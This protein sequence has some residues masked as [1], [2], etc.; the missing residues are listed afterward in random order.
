MF[1][2]ECSADNTFF[3]TELQDKEE[4]IHLI[5]KHAKQYLNMTA[6]LIIYF[7]YTELQDKKEII[8]LT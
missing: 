2:Y 4:M 3:L 8:H 1:K 6:V 7:S 5:T